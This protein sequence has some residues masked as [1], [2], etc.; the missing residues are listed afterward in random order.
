MADENGNA[1]THHEDVNL[2][3]TE[4]PVQDSSR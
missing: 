3:V 4:K 1:G 2:T